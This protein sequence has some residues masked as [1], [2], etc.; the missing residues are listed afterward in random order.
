MKE[1][2]SDAENKERILKESQALMMNALKVC[3]KETGLAKGTNDKPP[4]EFEEY[5]NKVKLR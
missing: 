5:C 2:K 1:I 3:K 4:P